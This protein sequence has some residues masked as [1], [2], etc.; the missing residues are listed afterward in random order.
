M[1]TYVL[2]T[3][4]TPAGVKT[5]QSNPRR[6]KEVNKEIESLGCRIVAQY[7][8]LGRYD[9]VN[10]VEAKDNETIA[11]VSVNLGARGTVQIETPRLEPPAYPDIVRDDED[12]E[13]FARLYDDLVR[14]TGLPPAAALLNAAR[15]FQLGFDVRGAFEKRKRRKRVVSA[16]S[17]DMEASKAEQPERPPSLEPPGT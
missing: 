12:R 8:T 6:I 14:V 13:R 2:L 3:K 10:V 7:A 16:S 9:F 5:I 15:Q 4:V 11:K 17:A 1:A